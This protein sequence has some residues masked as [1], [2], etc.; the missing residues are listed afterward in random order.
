MLVDGVLWV[1]LSRKLLTLMNHT[2]LCN[3]FGALVAE[4]YSMVDI[5]TKFLNYEGERNV[6]V[7]KCVALAETRQSLPVHPTKTRYY[8]SHL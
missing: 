8:F 6:Y 3:I 2:F 4:L 1:Q 5:K 7:R